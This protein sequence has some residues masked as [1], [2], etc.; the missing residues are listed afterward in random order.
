M[1]TI[2]NISRLDYK[3][4][5]SGGGFSLL[6][7][8][9][10]FEDVDDMKEIRSISFGKFLTIEEFETAKSLFP[11][12]YNVKRLRGYDQ[13]DEGGIDFKK[14]Y[15]Q[16]YFS[17]EQHWTNKTTGEKNEAAEIRLQRVINKIKQII[18]NNHPVS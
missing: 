8:V 3:N 11:K 14:P 16:L 1:N 15:F 6:P 2:L 17:F 10:S 5:H 18:S 12:S 7:T 9:S 4:P 13:A